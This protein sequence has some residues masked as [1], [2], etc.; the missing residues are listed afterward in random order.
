M[1]DICFAPL[2]SDV[3][4]TADSMIL[5]TSAVAGRLTGESRRVAGPSGMTEWGGRRGRYDTCERNS[6]DGI[7]LIGVRKISYITNNLL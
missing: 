4:L 1:P 6:L 7:N 3:S 5:L 2:L